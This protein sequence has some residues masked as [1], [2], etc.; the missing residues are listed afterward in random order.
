MDT[1]VVPAPAKLN[2]FLHVT[3]RRADGYHTLESLLVLL[4]FGDVLTLSSRDDGKIVLART[5]PGVPAE[6]D[7]AFRAA[8]LLQQHSKVEH[9]VTIDL[10]KRIP[11]GSGMGGG[12]S[13]AAS[14]L[15]AL[16]R[17]W[18][19]DLSRSELMRLG[20]QLGAD[21]P[22]FVFGANAH[23]TGVGEIL[24]EVTMPRLH[25]LIEVPPV[26]SAT[27]SVF[28]AAS[29]KRDTPQ[30]GADAFAP[31]FGRNDLQ[32]VAVSMHS[33][34]ATSIAA[35]DSIGTGAAGRNALWHA[36]MTGSGSAV[37]RIFDRG[38]PASEAAWRAAGAR[39]REAWKALQHIHYRSPRAHD[40]GG[41][42]THGSRLIH[43]RGL[44][45]HPLRDFVAK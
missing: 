17:M 45:R 32:P 5:L 23:M 40:A 42:L 44:Q 30:T 3:G 15:L 21:V 33:Q 4:D 10:D 37:F 18:H 25:F 9:G 7:L 8:S 38:F 14:V 28:A 34:I 16:N 2:L 36:R 24:R 31:D 1:L 12:S 22:L 19:L 13:D 26:N 27:A 41:T 43:A 11:M 35:L 20:L 39:D 29:L 6:A